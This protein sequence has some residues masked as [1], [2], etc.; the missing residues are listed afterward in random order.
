MPQQ[1]PQPDPSRM[2]PFTGGAIVAAVRPGSDPLVALTAADLARVTGG[3]L[4]FAF[5][6]EQRFVEREL[7]D[8]SVRHA[9][10]NPDA[11]D[12]AWR[13]REAGMTADL[14]RLL[15]DAGVTWQFRYLAG[16]PDRAL[17]HLARAVDAAVIVVGHH[18]PERG[19]KV[20]EFLDGAL[21]LKLAQ[22]QH[23]PVLAVPLRVVD[24]KAPMPWG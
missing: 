24:W 2:T 11:G 6:D 12:D 10:L 14:R 15:A 16:R 21:A 9:D 20:R 3:T 19:A 4:Y 5:V 23:R 7:P 17:T 18:A 13:R 22:H 1:V 8:G